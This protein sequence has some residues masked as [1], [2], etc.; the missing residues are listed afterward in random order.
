MLHLYGEGYKKSIMP[1][2]RSCNGHLGRT[3]YQTFRLDR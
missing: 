1:K 2:G 3:E